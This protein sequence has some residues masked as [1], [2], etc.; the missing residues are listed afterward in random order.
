MSDG[1]SSSAIVVRV[2][3]PINVLQRLD[4]HAE[5]ARQFEPVG[6]YDPIRKVGFGGLG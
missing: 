5:H 1:S 4:R 6:A 2:M 3:M